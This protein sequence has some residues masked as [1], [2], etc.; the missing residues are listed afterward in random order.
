MSE[1]TSFNVTPKKIHIGFHEN[2]AFTPMK[3]K[4]EPTVEKQLSSKKDA[5]AYIKNLF[6]SYKVLPE[7]KNK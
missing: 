3:P 1:R 2:S 4:P 5:Y 7:I 6:N